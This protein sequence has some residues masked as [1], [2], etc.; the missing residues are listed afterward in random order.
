MTTVPGLFGPKV[1]SLILNNDDNSWIPGYLLY[2]RF[3]GFAHGML[4]NISYDQATQETVWCQNEADFKYYEKQCRFR[5]H[6]TSKKQIRLSSLSEY[7]SLA[8]LI[9]SESSE[10][11]VLHVDPL[12]LSVVNKPRKFD[13]SDS[14]TPSDIEYIWNAIQTSGLNISEA[15]GPS[16][17]ANSKVVS[18][19]GKHTLSAIQVAGLLPKWY[20]RQLVEERGFDLMKRFPFNSQQDENWQQNDSFKRF[21]ESD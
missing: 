11:D 10:L 14:L 18:R 19:L 1:Y 5:V 7:T 4:K 20:W 17:L 15:Q 9:D 21:I 6:Y 13:L 16:H 3:C 2:C 12:V 8:S